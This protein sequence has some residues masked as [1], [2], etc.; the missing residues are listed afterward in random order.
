MKKDC[1]EKPSSEYR[2]FIYDS[3]N[4]GMTYWRSK[5]DR[6]EAA[7]EYIASYLD[8]GEWDEDV[9][10]ISTGEVTHFPQLLDKRNRPPESEFDAETCDSDGEFWGDYE[11]NGS[12][13][14]KPVCEV[15]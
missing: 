13:T 12:Y 3:E 4:G 15:P 9:E 14:M 1:K 5:E 6:D 2:Y 7:K 10:C 11:L 8:E